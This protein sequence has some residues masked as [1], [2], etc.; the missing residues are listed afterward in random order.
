MPARKIELTKRWEDFVDEQVRSGRYMNAGEVLR[1]G[2][3]LL[4]IRTNEEAEK[5]AILKKMTEAGFAELDQG[6]GL[7]F[8]NLAQVLSKELSPQR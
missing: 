5:L 4:E 1:A 3:R 8:E 6:E 7:C 2:L